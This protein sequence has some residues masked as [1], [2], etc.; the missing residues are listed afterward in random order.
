[1]TT[2]AES[3]RADQG[4]RPVAGP[5][6]RRWLLW[7]A[8]VLALALLS[9][10]L[11]G[12]AARNGEALD[13]ENPDANG[14]QALARVLSERGVEVEVVRGLDALLDT[15]LDGVTLVAARTELLSAD[16]GQVLRDHASGAGSIVLLDPGPGVGELL[17]APVEARAFALGTPMDAGCQGAP[18]REGDRVDGGSTLVEVTDRSAEAR[19]CLP[20]SAGFGA[21]GRQAGHWVELPATQE[22]PRTLLLGIG[23]ALTNG[24]ITED[25]N[26]AV[27]LRALGGESRLVWYVAQPL[28]AGEAPARTLTDVLPEAFVPA[29]GVLLLAAV[30]WSLVRG[31]RLGRVVPEPLPV[32]IRSVETTQSRARLYQD[33]ADRRRALASLQLAA[34]RRWAERLGLPA[35]TAVPDLLDAVAAA[36][37]VDRRELTRV[38]ADADAD[39][40]E[41]LVR[42][43]RAARSLEEGNLPR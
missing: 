18:W 2:S 16:A 14:A 9:A 12:L 39:D 43:A 23:E 36:T 22:R 25:A 15:D 26:A 38:L 41:T 24:R 40:D 29:V 30:A 21:G 6:Y 7:A 32:V 27:G 31:R 11:G 1:V 10:V 19:V 33:A 17:D 37:G 34:R 35:T 8:L 13:P 3:V 20:P 5:R 42:T 28:D 4:S